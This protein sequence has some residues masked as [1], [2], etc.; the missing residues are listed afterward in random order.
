MISELKKCQ[1]ANTKNHPNWGVGYVGVFPTVL[2]Y[3]QHLKT[4]ISKPFILRG[5]Q[6][7]NVHK[8]FAGLRDVWLYTVT[9]KRKIFF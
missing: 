8:M 9:K 6:W 3:G 2:L 5:Y 4:A 1:E 7:Y